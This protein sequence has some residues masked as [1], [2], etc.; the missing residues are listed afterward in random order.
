MDDGWILLC[1]GYIVCLFPLGFLRFLSSMD[2]CYERL[3]RVDFLMH[4]FD[5]VMNDFRFFFIGLNIFLS[6]I[7]CTEK[8]WMRLKVQ[9]YPLQ[10]GFKEV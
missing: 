4:D 8:D 7:K 6:G 10:K 2:L 9:R 3:L 1:T 5:T